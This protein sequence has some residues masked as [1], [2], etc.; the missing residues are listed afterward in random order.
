M[1]NC[2]ADV[3]Q[4]VTAIVT[5][6]SGVGIAIV[7]IYLNDH[8]T[9]HRENRRA[10]REDAAKREGLV[11]EKMEEVVVQLGAI[12]EGLHQWDGDLYGIAQSLLRKGAMPKTGGGDTVQMLNQAESLVALYLPQVYDSF[13]S[14]QEATLA[15]MGYLNEQVD[16]I[17]SDAQKWMDSRDRLGG[18]DS[19][20]AMRRAQFSFIDEVREF[21]LPELQPAGNKKPL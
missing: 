11:R 7:T 14:F 4:V 9:S 8:T 10:D 5:S 12:V 15:Y 19:Y 6:L 21:L 16:A 2:S 20:G 17:L 18:Q 3:F 1:A 13:D